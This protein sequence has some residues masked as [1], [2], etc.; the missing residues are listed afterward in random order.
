MPLTTAVVN[1]N[2]CCTRYFRK[3]DDM[4]CRRI[5]HCAILVPVMLHAMAAQAC[6]VAPPGQ[7]IGV[8]E[9][10]RQATQVAVGQV[11]SATPLS[12]HEVE[13]RFLTLEPLAGEP[14]K[15]FTVMGR[16][17]RRGG[18]AST[19]NGHT[20][21]SFWARGGGRVMNDADC[22]IHPYFVVGSN[23]LIFLGT[24]VTRRSFEQIDMVDGTVSADDQWLKY[25]R[26]QLASRQ[27]PGMATSSLPQASGR[28]F[29]RMGRF[30]YRFHRSIARDDLDRG[31]LAARHAPPELL[32][33]A[34]AL[35]DEFDHIVASNA[36]SDAEL[37]ATLRESVAV[38]SMLAAWSASR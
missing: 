4:I 2:R 20:D 32:L 28:D 24:P 38:A 27:A 31:T 16:A 19:F 5:I 25:V 8:D 3:K 17:A 13:Y 7:L 1:G 30:I 34:G 23:Y 35:A 15:V 22:A 9:Q 12:D 18:N 26:Q 11:I 29:E 33:R 6:R 21:F 37:D 14:G 10:M 36:A